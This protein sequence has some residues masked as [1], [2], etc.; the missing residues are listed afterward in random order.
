M[1]NR[2]GECCK[3]LVDLN[4]SAT[5]ITDKGLVHLCLSESGELR[6]Q[7]LARLSISETWISSAGATVVLYFLPNLRE[8]D[9]DNI[10][11]VQL[12]KLP[13]CPKVPVVLWLDYIC[14]RC[15]KL[16]KKMILSQLGVAL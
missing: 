12:L 10:F 9:F 3:N 16:D 1:V 14:F 4:L 2:I 15:P 7:K 6:C 11:E 13:L 5:P 8:F